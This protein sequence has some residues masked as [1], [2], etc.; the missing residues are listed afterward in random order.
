MRARSSLTPGSLSYAHYTRTVAA[1][2][3][4]TPRL[5]TSTRRIAA[6]RPHLAQIRLK[7]TSQHKGGRREHPKEIIVKLVRLSVIEKENSKPEEGKRG[8]RFA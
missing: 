6:Q 2:A 1:G 4:S 3:P 7:V 5:A 8:G